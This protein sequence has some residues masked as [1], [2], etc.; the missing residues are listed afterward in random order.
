M[1]IQFAPIILLYGG[2][3][4]HT[5]GYPGYLLYPGIISWVSGYGYPPRVNPGL[6]HP[7][8]NSARQ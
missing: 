3:V 2:G 5:L 7:M 1:D 6:A 8:P 4:W